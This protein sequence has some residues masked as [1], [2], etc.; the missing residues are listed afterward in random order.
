MKP[1]SPTTSSYVLSASMLLAGYLVCSFLL[2]WNLESRLTLGE[3]VQFFARVYLPATVVFLA[4]G[5]IVVAAVTRGEL[6]K[7][8]FGET[9]ALAPILLFGLAGHCAGAE[10]NSIQEHLT[11]MR[12]P[13]VSRVVLE[14]SK[15]SIPHRS[16]NKLSGDTDEWS[17]EV[18]SLVV[19]AGKM[20]PDGEISGPDGTLVATVDIDVSEE[21]FERTR[22]GARIPVVRRRTL[23]GDVLSLREARN[24]S[25]RDFLPT[26]VLLIAGSLALLRIRRSP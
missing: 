10:I 21:L 22:I 24:L 3:R 26:I 9:K 7:G 2:L 20:E 1:A 25:V 23:F 11:S 16:Y 15:Y 17:E 12:R 5:M 13:E 6:V 14:K 8:S 18:F 4:L 19:R